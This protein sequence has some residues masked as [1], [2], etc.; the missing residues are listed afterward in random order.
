MSRGSRR[1]ENRWKL[2]DEPKKRAA[3]DPQIPKVTTRSARKLEH[4][5]WARLLIRQHG[6]EKALQIT[7]RMAV[8]YHIGYKKQAEPNQMKDYYRAAFNYMKNEYQKKLAVPAPA[9][10]KAQATPTSG[11]HP[12]AST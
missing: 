4:S 12:E 11:S 5:A 9:A 6:I 10:P 7:R 8:D 2:W 3:K 1:R